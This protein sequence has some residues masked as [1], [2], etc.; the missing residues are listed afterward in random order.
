MTAESRRDSA[1]RGHPP[2]SAV[3]EKASL[4]A[5]QHAPIRSEEPTT[6]RSQIGI[7]AGASDD[8][9]PEARIRLSGKPGQC[10]DSVSRCRGSN[11]F[12]A[13]LDSR[14]R[15]LPAILKETGI[16]GEDPRRG[17]FALGVRNSLWQNPRGVRGR[18]I[19]SEPPRCGALRCSFGRNTPDSSLTSPCHLGASQP[20]RP[21]VR[22]QAVR[23]RASIHP[24]LTIA[25][26]APNSPAYGNTS[27]RCRAPR[28]TLKKSRTQR[29]SFQLNS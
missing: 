18:C 21:H 20:S 13:S 12:Q 5:T 14:S 11:G 7:H 6:A 4:M 19:P 27:R 22:P 23:F 16:V 15:I 24:A 26:V 8:A 28:T 10:A 2:G 17:L 29:A 1:S 9:R 3:S 25:D